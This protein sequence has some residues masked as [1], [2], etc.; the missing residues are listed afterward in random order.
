[1]KIYLEK[2]IFVNRAPF[3]KL[4]LNFN[5]NEI[6]VLSA[7]NGK[8]KTTILSYIVDAFYEMVR[9]NFPHEFEGK[10]NKLYRISS[11]IFNL[12]QNQPSFVYLRF[13]TTKGNID[14][15]DV[16]S[17]NV[18][19]NL[20]DQYD[21]VITIDEKIEFKKLEKDIELQKYSKKVS[22]SFNKAEMKELFLSNVLTYFPSYR[23]EQPS[24]LNEPY[25]FTLEFK[26]TFNFLGY[27]PNPIEVVTGF[28]Q[29]ANWIMDIVLD[30][31]AFYDPTI[32][33][34]L[35]TKG[36]KSKELFDKHTQLFNN[37]NNIITL[38]LISKKYSAL[39]FGIGHRGL[40]YSR[41]QVMDSKNETIYP[42]IF[43]MSSGESAI[44]CI[45]GELLRQADNNKNDIQL[46]EITGIVLIDEV[47][48]HLHIKLQK[49]VLPKLFDLFP[50]VQ[51]IVSSHSPFL[52]M[53]LAEN[54]RARIKSLDTGLDIQP[55]SDH[56]YEEVYNMMI[57]ENERFKQL[58]DSLKERSV[59]KGTKPLII[60]EGKTDIQHIKKAKEKLNI[61]LELDYFEIPK[62]EKSWGSSKLKT[63][64][65][66]ICKIS[67]GRKVIGIFDRD[68]PEILK[69]IE[70]NKQAFKNYGNN[71]Y[72]F[73]LPKV[74]VEM[75][76]EQISIEHYYPESILKKEN[77][78]GRRLFLGSEF[79][80]S[81]NSKDGK[82]Q[83]KISQIEN[84]VK[85]NGIIDDKVHK[86]EDL[87]QK[88]SIALSKA[89]FANLIEND[90]EFIGDF[91]FN[92]F[93]PV[94]NKIEEI[95]NN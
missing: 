2:A 63:L 39:G 5:E 76:G 21:R 32:L 55:T 6:A 45:F 56:Q 75:Y 10:E 80:K 38:T 26:K 92:N 40:G 52:S 11:I 95:L 43:S 59:E 36:F 12:K 69:D 42:S 44:L 9:L 68:E 1:M 23:Y 16:R 61:D 41:V 74:N 19:N 77:K 53:G 34:R 66:N 20:H 13:R 70:K 88:N 91:D 28:Q 17:E 72:A 37:L 18:D 48:K 94:F 58:Y 49:E 24:Y 33:R 22:L 29:L 46:S 79:Y 67:N 3:D 73:C 81:G 78:D 60:T 84:K 65:E 89:D 83:T 35:G 71:V 15:V 7:V 4:E 47:D 30:L 82:Y 50:N 14:Y 27:L 93:K 8:G 85:I 57:G 64:L 90:E 51:F 54:S 62:T 86:R 31:R 87:E 25:K